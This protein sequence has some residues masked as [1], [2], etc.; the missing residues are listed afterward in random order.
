MLLSVHDNKKC[1]GLIQNYFCLFSM[2]VSIATRRAC[3]PPSNSVSIRPLQWFFPVWEMWRSELSVLEMPLYVSVISML[4]FWVFR[5]N[6]S[7]G[8]VVV[9]T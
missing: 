8:F 1:F 5:V 3:L 4:A 6:L 2:S 7:P 9:D